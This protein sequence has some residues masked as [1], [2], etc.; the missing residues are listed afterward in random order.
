[1]DT[2]FAYGHIQEAKRL[3]E[4]YHYTKYLPRTE[5]VYSLHAGTCELMLGDM[6]AA[7]FFGIP[8][9]RWE[10]PVLELVRLVRRDDVDYPLTSLIAFACRDL[11]RRGYDLLISYADASYGHHGGIY[12]AAS[13]AYHGIDGFLIEGKF[14]AAR[15]RDHIFG[16]SALS[17]LKK[18]NPHLNIEPSYDKGKHLYWRA[19]NNYGSWKAEV[20]DLQSNPY[21]KPS[22][23]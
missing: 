10:H 22:R 3:V 9:S 4:H 17:I 11:R 1:M 14:Y 19:L 5:H 7:C 18:E 2:T 21:P 6:L 15:T 8:G 16:S 23:S 20:L 13:W 12:Q